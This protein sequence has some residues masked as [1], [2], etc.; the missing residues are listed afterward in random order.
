M[1]TFAGSTRRELL[2]WTS[3]NKRTQHARE[4]SR[5]ANFENPPRLTRGKTR[6][7]ARGDAVVNDGRLANALARERPRHLGQSDLTR[8]E[9]GL[10]P[11]DPL[12]VMYD[13]YREHSR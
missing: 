2:A 3:Y 9:Y 5:S 11:V 1:L 6:R 10:Q 4:H 7:G 12:M 13:A 8:C